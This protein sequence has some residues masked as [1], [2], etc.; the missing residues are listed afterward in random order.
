MSVRHGHGSSLHIHSDFKVVGGLCA[1]HAMH[2][3]A[4]NATQVTDGI[5][6]SRLKQADR[7]LTK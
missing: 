7:L 3:N 1:P 4:H 5:V 2:G 6:N